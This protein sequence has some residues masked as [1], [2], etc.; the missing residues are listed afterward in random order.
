MPI[1]TQLISST[2]NLS[3]NY[4]GIKFEFPTQVFYHRIKQGESSPNSV[5]M[6]E[7]YHYL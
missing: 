4:I 3:I 2:L 5:I 6:I 1:T 7:I